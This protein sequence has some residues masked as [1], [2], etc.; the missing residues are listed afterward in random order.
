[1][2]RNLTEETTRNYHFYAVQNTSSLSCTRVVDENREGQ[3]PWNNIGKPLSQ[4]IAQILD[5]DLLEHVEYIWCPAHDQ[6]QHASSG[7]D[8]HWNHWKLY[9]SPGDPILVLNS[10]PSIGIAHFPTD[11]QNIGISP[12][13][14]LHNQR[15]HALRV[16]RGL[17]ASCH[18]QFLTPAKE[19]NIMYNVRVCYIYILYIYIYIHIII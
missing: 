15:L 6:L 10:N 19:A 2:R 14:M 11:C 1:M 4:Q 13:E 7:A 17:G 16:C 9:L 5:S 18:I 12:I 3:W 8:L